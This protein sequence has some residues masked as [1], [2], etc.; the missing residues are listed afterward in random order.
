MHPPAGSPRVGT[1]QQ[2]GLR[3]PNLSQNPLCHPD[4]VANRP[5][6]PLEKTKTASKSPIAP[7]RVL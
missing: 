2:P 1:T 7:A 5:R 4:P 3:G 6:A